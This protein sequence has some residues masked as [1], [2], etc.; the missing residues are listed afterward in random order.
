M[1]A[2]FR[3]ELKSYFV[4][5]IGYVFLAAFY[6]Y[7]GLMFYV[8]GLS[9]GKTRMDM[10]F[11]SLV[12]V[13]VVLIPILTMRTMAEERRSKTDQCL[14][15]SPV[16]IGGMIAGKFLAAFT[17]YL[18]AISITIIM[19]LVSCFFAA[20]DWSVVL[21]NFAGLALLGASYI[22]IGVFCSACTESQSVSA[23]LSFGVLLCV[24]FISSIASQL[25]FKFLTELAGKISFAE[26]YYTFTYGI[27]DISNVLF[28]ISAAFVFL[29]L[30]VR[31][32]EKR[33][34]S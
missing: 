31:I 29:F 26:R 32:V 4:T 27:F 17:V 11:S 33:R 10:L 34:W 24:T 15:T 8:T 7:A 13:L 1:G 20:P 21:G 23:V 22:A 14:L 6:A 28:F 16:S 25:P 30:T 5:P 9:E 12:I 18:A 3:R 19:A 2:V